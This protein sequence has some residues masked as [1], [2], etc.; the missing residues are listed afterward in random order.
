MSE[1]RKIRSSKADPAP[2]AWA[3]SGPSAQLFIS[4]VTLHKLEHGVLLA[5]RKDP[6]NGQPGL[7]AQQDGITATVFAFDVAGTGSSTS[8]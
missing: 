3:A 6:R 2:A 1:Q 5:E 4:V 8:G 7:V